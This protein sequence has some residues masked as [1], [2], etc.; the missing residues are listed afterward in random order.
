MI[1]QAREELL[2]AE[3]AAI[4]DATRRGLISEEVYHGLIQ[5]TDYR[6]EALNRIKRTMSADSKKE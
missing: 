4:S 3:R 2:Q 6:V 1:M 5:E